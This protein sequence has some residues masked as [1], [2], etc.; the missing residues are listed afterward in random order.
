MGFQMLYLKRDLHHL[1]SDI[2]L[3]LQKLL[4]DLYSKIETKSLEDEANYNIFSG[5]I[6]VNLKEIEKAK[7]CFSKVIS[8]EKQLAK[9]KELIWLLPN[10]MQELAEIL[11]FEGN[12]DESEHLFSRAN[13]FSGFDFQELVQNRIR[14]S[15]ET[16]KKEKKLNKSSN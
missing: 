14:N 7:E 8:L 9:D 3:P 15:I 12:L 1:K 2:L 11:Y 16:I 6:Y 13:K 4:N 5:A 10:A